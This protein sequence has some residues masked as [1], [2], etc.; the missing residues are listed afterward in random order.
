ML[1]HDVQRADFE[2][3]LLRIG[4]RGAGEFRH[5]AAADHGDHAARCA[6]H[7]G[8]HTLRRQRIDVGIAFRSDVGATRVAAGHLG[9]GVALEHIDVGRRA[10][11]RCADGD[12]PDEGVAVGVI[13]R[14]DADRLVRRSAAV[15]ASVQHRIAHRRQR[16][17][18]DHAR[19]RGQRDA[20]IQAASHVGDTGAGVMRGQCVDRDAAHVHLA[21][22]GRQI[23][24]D[25]G[26]AG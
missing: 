20:C 18:T 14:A 25:E 6:D 2:I 7:H 1:R 5:R 8:C 21:A 3:R 26:I 10:D 16:F 24:R 19:A 9:D 22:R 12:G 15:V 13:R 23:G 11:T 17:A 4:F